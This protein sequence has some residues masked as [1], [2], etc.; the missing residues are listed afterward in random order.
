MYYHKCRRCGA[1]LDPGEKCDCETGERSISH[2]TK[3]ITTYHLK[4]TKNPV[5]YKLTGQA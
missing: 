1:N 4:A 2:S 5:R 3:I